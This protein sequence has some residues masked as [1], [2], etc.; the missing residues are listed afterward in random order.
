METPDEQD[1][2][3]PDLPQQEAKPQIEFGESEIQILVDY[4]FETAASLLDLNKDLLNWQ[5]HQAPTL[6]LVKQFAEDKQTRSLVIAKVDRSQGDQE[7]PPMTKAD[8]T[9]QMSMQTEG[10]VQVLFSEKVEYL[11]TTAQTIAFLKRESYAVLDL[12]S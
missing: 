7:Q 1:P 11:G 10:S 9:D 8:D 5:L 2:T 6:Q 12:R 3:T 4:L